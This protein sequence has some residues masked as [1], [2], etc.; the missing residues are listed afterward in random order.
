MLGGFVFLWM[1]VDLLR[2]VHH[3]GGVAWAMPEIV[4]ADI[5][6]TVLSLF[7]AICGLGI[8]FYATQKQHRKLWVYGA[9]LLGL[10][11]VK[12][13][14]V[15]LSAQETIERIVSFTGVGVLLTLVG[16]FSP[17]PPKHAVDENSVNASENTSGNTSVN[18]STEEGESHAS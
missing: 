5:S 10:V 6:Q 1:N 14:V 16:Y 8:T 3:W 12:L 15:D 13:F 7:W 4:I 17:I 11:V 2:A 9:S 18:V